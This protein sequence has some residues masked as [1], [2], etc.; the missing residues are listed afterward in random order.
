MGPEEQSNAMEET[1]G[2]L[3]CFVISPIGQ[4]GSEMRGHMD[5]VFHCIIEPALGDRYKV[6]RGDHD[7]R[8]GRITQQFISDILENELIVCVLTGNNPNVY[9]ELAIAEAAARPIIVLRHRGDEIPFDVKD[10][11]FIEYDLEARQIFDRTYI[12][13][14]QQ[15]ERQLEPE[16]ITERK[17]P[18]GP[19]LTPLGKERLNF[20]AVERY[21]MLSPGIRDLLEAAE[22][23][24]WFCGI[25]L[26]G[27]LGNEGFVSLIKDRAKDGLECRFLLMSDQNPALEQM[28]SRGVVESQLERIR[29]DIRESVDVIEAL[30]EVAA[31]VAVRIV[32]HG[33]V[34]QQM[35]MS[36]KSMI[37]APHLYSRQTG[38]SPALQV[39]VTP[40][41]DAGRGLE[42]LFNSVREEFERLWVENENPSA[43][44]G[45][46]KKRSVTR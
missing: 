9:Y 15:A 38:Q 3:R 44:K 21:D 1:D 2:R 46:R 28:L 39:D 22:K 34:Y 33:I 20:R 40:T 10:L 17:V 4:Y 16:I 27:W 18:F 45:L 6:A 35:A 11:R 12:R 7:A 41:V 37:W 26:R 30:G 43:H 19:S 8:P 29:A 5:S 42:P 23:N 13:M 32:R 24:F 36:E 14:V 31:K 25:S